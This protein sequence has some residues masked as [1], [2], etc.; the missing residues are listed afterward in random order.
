[1]MIIRNFSVENEKLITAHFIRFVRSVM[2][3]SVRMVVF[4][5]VFVFLEPELMEVDHFEEVH[6]ILNF[7]IMEHQ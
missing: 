7:V 2:D 3:R 6:N 4:P 1:M 5:I